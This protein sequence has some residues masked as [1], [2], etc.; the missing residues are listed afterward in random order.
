VNIQ[1]GGRRMSVYYVPSTNLFGRGCLK[2]LAP[3]VSELGFKKAM[4]VTDKLLNQTG[5][6]GKVL[7]S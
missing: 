5:V 6:A 4:V 2:E 1:K 3:L 7:L